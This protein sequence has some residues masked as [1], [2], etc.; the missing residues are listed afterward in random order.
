MYD[1]RIRRLHFALSNED[2]DTA[3][4]LLCGFDPHAFHHDA[5]DILMREAVRRED[6]H[7]PQEIEIASGLFEAL[8]TVLQALLFNHVSAEPRRA[9]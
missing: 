4:D 7:P 8:P 6:G 5:W 3:I 9:A 2:L 1:G